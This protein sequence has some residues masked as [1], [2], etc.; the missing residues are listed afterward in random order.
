MNKYFENH[1][2]LK[3]AV[4]FLKRFDLENLKQNEIVVIF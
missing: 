1:C 3:E 2:F 4:F